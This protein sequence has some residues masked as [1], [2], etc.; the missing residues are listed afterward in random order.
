M[1][2]PAGRGV[3]LAAGLALAGCAGG[4]PDCGPSEA[5]FANHGPLAVEQL[6]LMPDGA[7]V[8]APGWGDDLLGAD[9]LAAGAERPLPLP[10][11]GR[12]ALRAVWAD[13]RAAELRGID[14][15]RTRT[16]TVSAA[17]LRAE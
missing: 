8:G 1:R 2:G 14:G 4:R 11:P 12:L 5:R 10:G 6:Y 15:C 7:P 13:G 9:Q 17:G 3:A 16:V